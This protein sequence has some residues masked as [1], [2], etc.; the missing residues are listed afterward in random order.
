[1]TPRGGGQPDLV[2]V[3]DHAGIFTETG[4]KHFHLHRRLVVLGLGPE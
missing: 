3:D 1:M 2:A 4:Q